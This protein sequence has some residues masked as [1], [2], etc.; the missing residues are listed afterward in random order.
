MPRKHR[1]VHYEACPHCQG[2]GIKEFIHEVGHKIKKSFQKGGIVHKIASEALNVAKPYVRPVVND[3][4]NAGKT[5]L[6]AYAP[7]LSHVV[8]AGSQ[9][10]HNQIDKKLTQQGMGLGSR[11]GRFVKGSAEAK[12]HMQKLRAMRGKGLTAPAPHSRLP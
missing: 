9:V 1:Q 11:K 5:A 3:L 12:E 6:Q 10:I 8:E 7:E 4:L 2:T